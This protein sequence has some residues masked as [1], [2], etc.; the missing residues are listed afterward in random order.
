MVRCCVREKR[1]RRPPSAF[2]FLLAR[3]IFERG[4]NKER[5][6]FSAA[7][8]APR[9]KQEPLKS[10]TL[11][12]VLRPREEATFVPVQFDTDVEC[13]TLVTFVAGRLVYRA[14]LLRSFAGTF[15]PLVRRGPG[16]L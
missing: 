11:A 5:S 15:T 3:E 6:A 2:E 4:P 14:D 16:A 10:A 13:M 7:G 12:L 9:E 1:R 8:K